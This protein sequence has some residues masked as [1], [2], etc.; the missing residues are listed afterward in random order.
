[1]AITEERR[2]RISEGTLV[3]L[4]KRKRRSRVRPRDYDL[5]RRDGEVS[6]AI[7]PLLPIAEAEALD[8]AESMGGLDGLSAQEGL[9]I[10]DT[11]RLGLLVTAM[12]SLFAT[13]PS[14]D[15][16][17]RLGTL[18]GQRRNHLVSLGLGRRAKPVP[19][20]AELGMVEVVQRPEYNPDAAQAA[21]ER[22]IG[23][24][25]DP[26]PSTGESREEGP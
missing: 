11:A 13:S 23:A 6:E 3:G 18:L 8:L 9:I 15:I 19:T 16:A 21:P 1:M 20:L 14:P 24:K 12:F 26:K 10:K 4:E 7:K 2:R 17:T 5:L 25:S 22:V